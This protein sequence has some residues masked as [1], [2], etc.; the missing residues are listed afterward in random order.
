MWWNT[1]LFSR[2]Y[3]LDIHFL[4]DDY[5]HCVLFLTCMQQSGEVAR[6]Y[7]RFS[8]KSLIFSFLRENINL[9]KKF[10]KILFEIF[11]LLSPKQCRTCK[12]WIKILSKIFGRL[13]FSWKNGDIRLYLLVR[14]F[15]VRASH[16]LQ[17]FFTGK[18]LHK[19]TH[20]HFRMP[21]F[22]PH[23]PHFDA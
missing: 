18:L 3:T 2:R 10:D 16:C 11:H 22:N 19:T 12:N 5:T 7:F 6:F 14:F 20:P 4:A 17:Y 1:S 15:R 9:P 13:T 8:L 23:T 21:I